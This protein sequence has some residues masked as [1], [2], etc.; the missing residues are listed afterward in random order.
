MATIT[1][2]TDVSTGIANRRR[3]VAVLDPG[4]M[5]SIQDVARDAMKVVIR[6]GVECLDKD[7]RRHWSTFH[8]DIGF[9]FL[10]HPE[11][12]G[13]IARA[14][15]VREGLDTRAVPMLPTGRARTERMKT[16]KGMLTLAIDRETA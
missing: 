13:P 14:V 12:G 5:E 10:M 9:L 15:Y 1:E 4:D 3:A 7:G 16:G 6:N 11:G 8:A 2:I